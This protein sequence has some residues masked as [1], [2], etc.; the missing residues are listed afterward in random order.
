MAFV[1][2]E[3]VSL[4]QL[5]P[6]TAQHL[7]PAPG[8]ASAYLCLGLAEL[9][10]PLPTR[11]ES[12]LPT[13]APGLSHTAESLSWLHT[14]VPQGSAPLISCAKSLC[15]E[16]GPSPKVSSCCLRYC[17]ILMTAWNLK[18]NHSA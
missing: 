13:W 7:L 16:I 18:I 14:S 1:L 8:P 12:C 5:Q 11:Q 6:F 4:G 15:L 10:D 9:E 3:L 2:K 17:S